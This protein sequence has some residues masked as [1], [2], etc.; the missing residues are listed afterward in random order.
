MENRSASRDAHVKPISIGL[1]CWRWQKGKTR[2]IMRLAQEAGVTVRIT[3]RIRGLR[4]EID[5]EVTGENTDLFIGMFV[6]EC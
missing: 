1:T 3:E 2:A 6:R 5:A 4:R